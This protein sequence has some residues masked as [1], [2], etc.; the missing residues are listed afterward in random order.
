LINLTF[1]GATKTVTGSKYLVTVDAQN[2]LVDCGLFQGHQEL[3]QRNWKSL[4]INPAHINAVILTH[5]HIDHSGYLPKLIKSGFKGKIYCTHGTRDLCAILLPDSGYLQEE[6]AQRAN[7]YGYSKHKPAIPLYTKEDGVAAINQFVPVPFGKTIALSPQFSF[8]FW[9]AGH[10]LGAAMIELHIANKT[11]VFSGDLGRPN[12]L[13]M[14]PPTFLTQADYLIL[15]S[16]YGDRLHAPENPLDELEALIVSTLAR[17]GSLIIPAFAVGRAQD[18]LFLLY[19]LRESER[20]PAIPIFLD[21][22]MAEDVS[23]LLIHYANEHRLNKDQCRKLCK[24]ATYARTPE[25]SKA[26]NDYTEPVIVISASGMIEGGRILHHL[27]LFL[28]DS[29]NTVLLTGY[30]APGTRGDQLERGATT[31]KIHGE[32][33]PV[34]AKIASMHNMS[35]HADYQEIL[36]W[37]THFQKHPTKVFLTHGDLASSQSL[38]HQI[39]AQ[40]GWSCLIPDYLHQELLR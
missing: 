12:Q 31:I 3:R 18:L 30:Q 24:I 26:I 20:I 8:T 16:T 17:K 25:E 13:I 32:N 37:L 23:D 22:P 11:V 29:R 34:R 5:A 33:I 27:K 21:S 9:P 19:Q 36:H 38:Q 28:P 1:F 35:A 7:R 15:E 2:I 4:P 39:E 40:F 6:D 14:K 10:I